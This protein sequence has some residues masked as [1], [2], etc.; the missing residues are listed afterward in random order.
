MDYLIVQILPYLLLTFG[1]GFI[2]GLASV[3]K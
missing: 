2:I 3:E 1:I